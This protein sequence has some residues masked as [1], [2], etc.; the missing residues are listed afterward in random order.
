[1]NLIL[2][3]LLLLLQT[4]ADAPGGFDMYASGKIYVVVAVIVLIFFGIVA[5]LFLLE[6]RL[7]R[8]EREQ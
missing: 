2:A 5:Y 8:L 1:M 3:N 4:S 6:R 7:K